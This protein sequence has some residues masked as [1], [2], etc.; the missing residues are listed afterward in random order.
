MKSL[1]TARLLPPGDAP[2]PFGLHL[3]LGP[4]AGGA[5]EGPVPLPLSSDE[6]TSR[7]YLGALKGDADSVVELVAVKILPN[8][9]PESLSESSSRP[10]NRTLLARFA[11]ERERLRSLRAQS[12][13]FPRLL[14]PDGGPDATLPA[15]LYDK[16][17]RSFFVPPCAACGRPLELLTDEAF[18]RERRLPSYLETLHRLVGC[19][20]CATTDRVI[21]VFSH[22]P[23]GEQADVPVGGPEDLLKGL[24]RAL[25]RDWDEEQVRGFASRASSEEAL[26]LRREGGASLGDFAARWSPFSFCPTPLLVT[27][28]SPVKW[29]EWSDFVGGRTEAD[30]VPPAA[31]ESLEAESCRR[32]VEW[33]LESLPPT[34]RFLY[35]HDGPGVDAVEVHYLK[36]TAFRQLAAAVLA[37]YRA[38]GQPHLDLH[39]GHVLLDSYGAGSALPALWTFEVRLHGLSSATKSSSFGVEVVVPPH[40]PMFPYAAPEILEFRLAARRPGDVYLSD[41]EPADAGLGVKVE[42]RLSDPNGLFPRPEEPDWIHVTFPDEALGLGIDA[43]VVRRKPGTPATYEELTFVSEPVDLD[44]A[45]VKRLRRS[46]GVRLPGARYKV[47]PRFGAPSD[48]H[49][50]GVLLLRVLAGGERTDFPL[51]LQSIQRAATAAARTKEGDPLPRRQ[52]HQRPDAAR[53]RRQD[54]ALEPATA[55]LFDRSRVFW[56]DED[57]V[58][59][60]PNAIPPALYERS[61]LLGLRLVT[62]IPGF[63]I[64]TAPGDFVPE[65]PTGRVEQALRETDEVVAELRSLLVHR[66]PLHFEIQDVLAELLEAESEAASRP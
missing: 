36:M 58:P 46:F 28:L 63:S 6:G 27:G 11:A 43:L 23:L 1:P 24:A 25:V 10:T 44:D 42:G 22:E 64:A 56:K 59:G 13:W 57:R 49:S 35:G 65:D 60:R 19:P 37:F 38:T 26:R 31:P 52:L 18:L 40:E 61:V 47:Y 32:R 48:L 41:I 39:P 45:A 51:V 14:Q 20:S 34:G 3:V 55:A 4:L 8:V 21:A 15:L 16:P 33:L 17:S 9:L 53:V 50:L 5:E 54:Q 7:V 12:P 30:L 66:Q 29:D 2:S 62:R